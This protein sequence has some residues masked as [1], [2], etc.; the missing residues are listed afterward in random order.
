M[1][2]KK[3]NSKM[4]G[5]TDQKRCELASP[6]TKRKSLANYAQRR[7][8]FRSTS[9]STIAVSVTGS[10]G[11]ECI[12]ETPISGAR[13]LVL[14]IEC[15]KKKSEDKI[16]APSETTVDSG[17]SLRCSWNQIITF[18]LF[19]MY[20]SQS[21]GGGGGWGEALLERLNKHKQC[22]LSRP[23]GCKERS[24]NRLV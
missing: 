18:K 7:K 16:F 2:V 6:I 11:V 5:V 19:R 4:E 21:G 13:L 3:P 22:S 1:S 23:E 17:C 12:Q 20:I 15:V 9:S 24:S 8:V 10:D 14:W